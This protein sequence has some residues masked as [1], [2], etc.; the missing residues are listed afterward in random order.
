MGSPGRG[1][2]GPAE[3]PMRVDVVTLFPELFDAFLALGMVG[4][5]IQEAT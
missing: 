5:R 2:A 3:G 1:A 4:K